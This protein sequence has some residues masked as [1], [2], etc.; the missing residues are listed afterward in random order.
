LHWHKRLNKRQFTSKVPSHNNKL[1]TKRRGGYQEATEER[2]E[3][4]PNSLMLSLQHSLFSSLCMIQA[5]IRNN[6]KHPSTPPPALGDLV[7]ERMKERNA[8]LFFSW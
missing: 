6:Y 3:E 7:S 2:R 8:L 4:G 1:S 5:Q